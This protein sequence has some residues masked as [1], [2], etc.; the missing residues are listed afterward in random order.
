MKNLQNY[1]RFII[2]E[3]NAVDPFD[4]ENWPVE[5]EE[6]EG[7]GNY[8]LYQGWVGDAYNPLGVYDSI[9]GFM[10]DYLNYNDMA[11]AHWVEGEFEYGNIRVM[12]DYDKYILKTPIE[13]NTL[14]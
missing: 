10:N 3:A 6:A 5:R 2:K 7:D 9:N 14:I 4:E 11:D 1:T 12:S 13:L 8:Y